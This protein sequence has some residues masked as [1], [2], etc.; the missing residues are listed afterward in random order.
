VLGLTGEVDGYIYLGSRRR[1]STPSR[2]RQRR[3]Y[4]MSLLPPFFGG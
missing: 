2:S 1:R 4:G 3:R